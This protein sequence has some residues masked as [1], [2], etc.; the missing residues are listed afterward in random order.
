M[1]CFYHFSLL[2][3]IKPSNKRM[4]QYRADICVILFVAHDMLL[5]LIPDLHS[6]FHPNP[7]NVPAKSVQQK[8]QALFLAQV[9]IGCPIKN[10]ERYIDSL[11]Q[12]EEPQGPKKLEPMSKS[13]DEKLTCWLHLSF[14]GIYGHI[15]ERLNTPSL[16]FLLGRMAA[17]QPGPNWA[18]MTRLCL[19]RDMEFPT[20]ILKNFGAFIP[21]IRGD[22]VKV[23]G[24]SRPCGHLL[25]NKRCIPVADIHWPQV[26]KCCL[27]FRFELV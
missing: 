26:L 11:S 2:F 4:P 24:L 10:M 19:C 15:P 6:L 14:P 1:S 12:S 20:L 25:C 17:V 21:G 13:E 9:I 7:R 16:L 8:C 18:V 27:N 22:L 23:R 3:Q 5:S